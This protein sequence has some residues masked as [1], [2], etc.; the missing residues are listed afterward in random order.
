[1]GEVLQD[2]RSRAADAEVRGALSLADQM[3][4]LQGS[5]VLEELQQVYAQILIETLVRV[6]EVALAQQILERLQRLPKLTSDDWEASGEALGRAT[7]L[8]AEFAAALALAET[9]PGLK[10]Y[11]TSLH[12]QRT[13][14]QALLTASLRAK[15]LTDVASLTQKVE[16]IPGFRDEKDV[17]FCLAQLLCNASALARHSR[18]I[19]PLQRHFQRLDGADS[20]IQEAA[21]R[22]KANLD[23]LL[24][25]EKSS[26]KK[27]AS[28]L[29]LAVG[30]AGL[31]VIGLGAVRLVDQPSGREATPTSSRVY[32]EQMQVAE[33]ARRDRDNNSAIAH[34]RLALEMAQSEAERERSLHFLVELYQE[35]QQWQ[36]ALKCFAQL[37]A[38][39]NQSAAAARLQEAHQL[40]KKGDLAQTELKIKW[41]RQLLEQLGASALE[42]D[43]LQ[44][45]LL[46]AQQKWAESAAIWRKLGQTERAVALLEK[47]GDDSALAS[48]YAELGAPYASKLAKLRIV[49]MKRRIEAAEKQ[50]VTHPDKAILASRG[51]LAELQRSNSSAELQARCLVVVARGALALNHLQEAVQAAKQAAQLAPTAENK[52]RLRAYIQKDLETV[53]SEEVRDEKNFR[54][55]PPVK[56]S[57]YYTYIYYFAPGR[58]AD[59]PVREELFQPPRDEIR[60]SAAYDN[61]SR[62]LSF[63]LTT[64][65]ART[66][67]LD[68]SGGREQLLK[69]GLYEEATRFP[70]NINNPGL[71]FSGNGHG[72]SQLR[73]KFVVHQVEWGPN[74]Q[75]TSFAADFFQIGQG[76]PPV[77]GKVRYYSKFK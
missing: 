5:V 30:L 17:Q 53:T 44:A 26:P 72:H 62:G 14:A 38:S 3:M 25:I 11:G 20:K 57:G 63:G 4:A 28:R 13:H 6:Q 76:S 47:S 64:Y 59:D 71:D 43:Q 2:W 67:S 19:V 54:F 75:V 61:P 16:A 29:T 33:K 24:E 27:S 69:P 58:E 18:D 68:L 10:G 45:D 55:P 35:S 70:F 12:L 1:M 8:P 46:E 65:D 36:A 77:Y 60:V 51:C 52:K 32:L 40:L 39:D 41:A 21:K 42:C 48:L 7:S 22:L 34:A 73:G 37:P 50:V 31:L 15:K 23:R 56:G 49:S 74:Q 66:Y 9:I